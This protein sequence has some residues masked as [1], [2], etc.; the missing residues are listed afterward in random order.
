MYKEVW[1][2]Y[3]KGF[4]FLLPF[5]LVHVLFQNSSLNLDSKEY[6]FFAGNF[7][8]FKQA[9]ENNFMPIL[10][11]L[12]IGSLF[13]SFLTVVIKALIN[14]KPINYRENL[15]QSLGV[16]FKYLVLT[17]ITSA[18][19]IGIM[20]LGFLNILMPIAFILMIYFNIILTPCKAYL[21]Y[22]NTSPLTA[23][24]KGIEVGKKYSGEILLLG[25]MLCVIVGIIVGIITAIGID[26]KTNPIAYAFTNFIGTCILFYL[27]TFAMTIC[28]K[29]EKS[30][31][32]IL[33]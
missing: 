28:K 5:I 22:N 26:V 12:F 25:V 32:Q 21:V 15:K 20:L 3:M 1:N 10:F 23:L 33:Y 17:I 27:A 4:K 11:N 16:Y 19:F 24:K 14:E 13:Y 2:K 9:V 6:D 31:G 18:I 30:E 7:S 29:E 8:A